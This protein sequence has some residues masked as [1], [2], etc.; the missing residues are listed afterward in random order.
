MINPTAV[1]AARL[2]W[3]PAYVLYG[4]RQRETIIRFESSIE[5]VGFDLIEH[6]GILFVVF[7][8]ETTV[9]TTDRDNSYDIAGDVLAAHSYLSGAVV[10]A[11]LERNTSAYMADR[12]VSKIVYTGHGWGGVLAL[13]QNTVTPADYTCT[14]GQPAAGNEDLEVKLKDVCA[15]KKHGSTKL[16]YERFTMTPDTLARGELFTA[17]E[18]FGT[19]ISM[20][21]VGACYLNP[22]WTTQFIHRLMVPSETERKVDAEEYYRCIKGAE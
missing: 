21:V 3:M 20:D 12:R 17:L 13:L 9:D 6:S 1:I 10:E 5:D 14:F 2:C 16:N 11:I 4:L 18:H 22:G 19:H 7:R 8:Y 15:S